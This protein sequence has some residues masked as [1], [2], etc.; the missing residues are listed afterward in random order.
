MWICFQPGLISGHRNGK[1]LRD[2]T[3]PPAP[4]G[5]LDAT[6]AAT[7]LP[8]FAL[9]LRSAPTSGP[10][11]DW[12]RRPQKTRNIGAGYS[13]EAPTRYFSELNVAENFDVLLFVEHTTAARKNPPLP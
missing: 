9:D 2:F 13:E 3:V 7:R 4:T 10:V 5:S 12:L 6:L 8:L 11:A 1:G